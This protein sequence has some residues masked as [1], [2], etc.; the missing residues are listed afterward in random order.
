MVKIYKVQAP[1]SGGF[2]QCGESSYAT[3]CEALAVYKDC[4]EYVA[5]RLVMV[6]W[7]SVTVLCQNYKG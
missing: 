7:H 1:V 4:A 5:V 6:D 2:Q 3:E